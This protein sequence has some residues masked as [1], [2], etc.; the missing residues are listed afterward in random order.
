[1]ILA[2]LIAEELVKM[3]D[4]QGG[5]D[6]KAEEKIKGQTADGKDKKTTITTEAHDL[7]EE[8]AEELHNELAGSEKK[9]DPNQGAAGQQSAGQQKAGGKKC[10]TC[11]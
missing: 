10:P 7:S 4:Q 11:G 3:A 8:E 2:P 9:P 6:I 5:V 1:M